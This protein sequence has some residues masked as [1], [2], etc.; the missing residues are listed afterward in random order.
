MNKGFLHFFSQKSAFV[1]FFFDNSCWLQ[2]ESY[3][4]VFAMISITYNNILLIKVIGN[5]SDFA[6]LYKPLYLKVKLKV[7][8]YNFIIWPLIYALFFL[9]FSYTDYFFQLY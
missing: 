6:K 7:S 4:P 8:V 2:L 1:L 9:L 3:F 5:T